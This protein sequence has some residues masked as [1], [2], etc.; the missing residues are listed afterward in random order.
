VAPRTT[1]PF[2]A[3]RRW[4]RGRLIDRLRAASGDGWLAIE[5]PIGTHDPDAVSAA[6][7]AL[8]R[9]GLVEVDGASGTG[10]RRA[11]LPV[12]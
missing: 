3:T 4:L 5:G 11:R 2:P 1:T 10:A 6:L 8:A 9:E 7:D 12:A